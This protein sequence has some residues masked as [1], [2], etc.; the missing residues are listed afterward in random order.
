ML[1]G[2]LARGDEPNPDTD[3]DLV[4]WGMS[5]GDAFVAGG[6]LGAQVGARVEVIPAE[7]MGPR[8]AQA[9]ETEGVEQL[10]V[11]D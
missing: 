9:V 7:W 3:V 2:S 1:I 10:R 11:A 8:L 5:L 4:V 6:D